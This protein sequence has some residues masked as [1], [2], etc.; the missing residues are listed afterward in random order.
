M[1]PAGGD[2]PRASCLAPRRRK[3]RASKLSRDRSNAKVWGERG[4]ESGGR[5]SE[6][7][8]CGSGSESAPRLSLGNE[9]L[10][11]RQQGPD[12]GSHAMN[13]L[14]FVVGRIAGGG[15]QALQELRS[16][17]HPGI[18]R[19]ASRPAC[20]DEDEP[21]TRRHLHEQETARSIAR[22]QN[23]GTGKAA[24]RGLAGDAGTKTG[25]TESPEV[26]KSL[27]GHAWSRDHKPCLSSDSTG[28][29]GGSTVGVTTCGSSS[30]DEEIPG[31]VGNA[32]A[33]RHGPAQAKVAE[34]A[35][36]PSKTCA[37]K[38]HAVKENAPTIE[39]RTVEASDHP[40]QKLFVPTEHALHHLFFFWKN[41]CASEVWL[42]GSFTDPPWSKLPL[43]WCPANRFHWVNVQ[44]CVPHISGHHHFKYIVDGTWMCDPSYPISDDGCGNLNNI[45]VIFPEALKRMTSQR[46]LRQQRIG[47]HASSPA[48]VARH[49]NKGTGSGL[50]TGP[51]LLQ[52]PL[53]YTRKA[54]ATP[55]KKSTDGN[56][57]LKGINQ[58]RSSPTFPALHCEEEDGTSGYLGQPMLPPPASPTVPHDAKLVPPPPESG[59]SRGL[60]RCAAQGNFDSLTEGPALLPSDEL[61]FWHAIHRYGYPQL[62]TGTSDTAQSQEAVEDDGKESGRLLRFEVQDEE[63]AT[64]TV[65]AGS[66]WETMSDRE[67]PPPGP[68]NRCRSA[69]QAGADSASLEENIRRVASMSV[70]AWP[71]SVTEHLHSPE[72]LLEL[73]LPDLRSRTNLE[74]L[75]GAA[76]I[77]HP[78][79]RDTNGADSLFI[80][81]AGRAVGVADGVG[82]WASWGL[83]PRMFAEELMDGCCRAAQTK[84]TSSISDLQQRCRKILE[85][86]YAETE[87]YGSATALVACVNEGGEELGVAVLGDSTLMVLRRQQRAATM[88]AVY[89]TREQQHRFNCPYQ[90]S[91]LPRPAE[92]PKLLED[93]RDTLVRVLQSATILPQDTP[94]IAAT[95]SLSIREGDLIILGTD[96]LF[97]N[98][99]ESEICALANL[100]LSPYEALLLHEPALVTPAHSVATALSEAAA[101][102]S[103]DP[104]CKTPFMKNARL[105]GAQYFG[106]KLD[107]ITVVACWV[108]RRQS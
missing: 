23:G 40:H 76:M 85:I 6:S 80:C 57:A 90:L 48:L 54:A 75:C 64:R 30:S 18:R 51:P 68:L 102:R 59:S 2:V 46:R 17:P 37:I 71:P 103:R 93:G 99:F 50:C 26:R 65:C 42:A 94:D 36:E 25:P 78:E 81:D 58:C 45:V 79:K 63:G 77:P 12:R 86:G 15:P 91:R 13:V 95:Y 89:R 19:P 31:T 60:R 100:A 47:L 24:V 92:Y 74:L 43:A 82:E 14:R 41:S 7:G 27:K 108:A 22:L 32:A 4:S 38:L 11:E 62:A 53:Q 28:T 35:I 8:S 56:V 16:K 88:T 97:D 73:D 21:F 1:Y 9:A 83:N 96:G 72:I 44:E 55:Q 66:Q 3:K 106:G 70:Q 87:S 29:S 107:D 52:P 67:Q 5:G 39:E 84:E 69:Y 104:I 49:G 101:H 105:A 20:Y 10:A 34:T 33:T 61:M 98:L